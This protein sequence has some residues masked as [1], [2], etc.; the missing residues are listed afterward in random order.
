[1]KDGQSI[2]PA[3]GGEVAGR[4]CPPPTLFAPLLVPGWLLGGLLL[5]LLLLFVT[6]DVFN[7]GLLYQERSLD[8]QGFADPVQAIEQGA[9]KADVELLGLK[10]LA[11]SF[12]GHKQHD[13][14]VYHIDA[15]K[16]VQCRYSLDFNGKVCTFPSISP[17]ATVLERLVAESTRLP[18]GAEERCVMTKRVKLMRQV[19]GYW[20]A[21]NRKGWADAPELIYARMKLGAVVERFNRR[22]ARGDPTLAEMKGAIAE[23]NRVSLATRERMA[24]GKPADDAV[25]RAA[26]A[27]KELANVGTAGLLDMDLNEEMY[28]LRELVEK[29]YRKNHKVRA[30]FDAAFA[31]GTQVEWNSLAALKAMFFGLPE[32]ER[33]RVLNGWTYAAETESTWEVLAESAAEDEPAQVLRLCAYADE[34][35]V[36]FFRAV[37]MVLGGSPVEL[38]IRAGTSR[39]EALEALAAARELIEK[40]WDALMAERFCEAE[41]R[42]G[43]S[44]NS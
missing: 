15:I 6:H 39:K 3:V 29:A 32:S 28:P 40:R 43:R 36:A 22:E 25:L 17:A 13:G 1:M 35:A 33:R 38:T 19:L 23:F 2:E 18:H 44:E 5:G 9:A 41:Q 12:F 14:E 7:D 30:A 27:K 37:R 16:V 10:S 31:D 34:R 26:N 20:D 8:A 4:T 11:I 24:G 42:S 21:C